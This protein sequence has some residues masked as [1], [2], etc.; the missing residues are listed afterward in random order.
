MQKDEIDLIDF[1]LE[2]EIHRKLKHPNIVQF[3]DSFKTP[4]RLVLVLEYCNGGTLLDYIR[5]HRK[6]S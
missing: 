5:N 6:L 4:E 1:Q 2:V 3:I